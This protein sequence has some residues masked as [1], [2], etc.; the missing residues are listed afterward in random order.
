MNTEELFR[1]ALIGWLL[2]FLMLN[3]TINTKSKWF[4]YFVKLFCFIYSIP[5]SIVILKQFNLLN[6]N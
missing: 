4:N 3:L 2:T 5:L 1:Y 6:L